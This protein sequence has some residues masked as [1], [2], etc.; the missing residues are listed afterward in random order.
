MRPLKICSGGCDGSQKQCTVRPRGQSDRNGKL[1]LDK[2]IC[3]YSETAIN[4]GYSCQLLT[5]EMEDVFIIN[6]ED[7]SSVQADIRQHLNRVRSSTRANNSMENSVADSVSVGI[8]P[9][10]YASDSQQN[11]VLENGGVSMQRM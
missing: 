11:S 4:I 6:G 10:S 2:V 3:R 8:L 7:E 5:D 1:P 9:G